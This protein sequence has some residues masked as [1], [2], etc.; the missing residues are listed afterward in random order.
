MLVYETFHATLA[1]ESPEASFFVYVNDIAVVTR[2]TNDM[3]RVVK[4]VQELSLIL[5]YQTNPGKKEVYKQAG[6]PRVRQKRQVLQHDVLCWNGKDIL[7]RPPIFRYL[8]HT[9][10]H[11]S[12]AQKA[13]DEV[14]AK[15]EF[16]LVW[17]GSLP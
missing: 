16:D 1:K 10:A 7:V 2:N 13:R 17:Y 6:T 5:G 15:V 12:W 3:Q 8:G 14:L 9:T 4:R 11:P